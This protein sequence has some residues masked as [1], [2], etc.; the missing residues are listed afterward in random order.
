MVKASFAPASASTSSSKTQTRPSKS[1]IEGEINAPPPTI[2]RR[3]RVDDPAEMWRFVRF[4]FPEV[5]RE[6]DELVR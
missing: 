1:R 4:E 6:S 5:L 3:E 2:N